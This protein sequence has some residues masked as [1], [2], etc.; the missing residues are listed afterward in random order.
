MA[1]HA[2][3]KT[4]VTSTLLCTCTVATIEHHIDGT[5]LR[6]A[7]CSGKTKELNLSVNQAITTV[8]SRTTYG[9][10]LTHKNIAGYQ[11]CQVETGSFNLVKCHKANADIRFRLEP[12]VERPLAPERVRQL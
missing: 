9:P 1:L 7:S 4:L 12:S 10:I 11:F 2:N 8:S 3:P 6:G 5:I